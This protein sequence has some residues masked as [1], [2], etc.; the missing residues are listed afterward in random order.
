MQ[1]QLN[2]FFAQ[3]F[4]KL[5]LKSPTLAM[6]VGV[7]LI[8]LNINLDYLIPLITTIPSFI[9]TIKLLVSSALFG[10]SSSTYNYLKKA[11]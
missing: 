2:I 3:I 7:L 4:A 6:G 9:T 1:D 11:E 8:I 5:K 10:V